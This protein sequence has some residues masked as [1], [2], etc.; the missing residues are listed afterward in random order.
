MCVHLFT[1]P[2][3]LIYLI[4][5]IV[6]IVWAC[7]PM[8]CE[9]THG[10]FFEMGGFTLIAPDRRDAEPKEQNGVVLSFDYF[11][12]NPNMDI[13]EITAAEI[14]DWSKGD[15]LWK[16]TKRHGSSFSASRVASNG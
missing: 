11:K 8:L 16:V 5:L 2:S 14:E 15:A 9:P 6:L 12:Q 13:P 3:D 1:L 7:T 10:H 4:Y